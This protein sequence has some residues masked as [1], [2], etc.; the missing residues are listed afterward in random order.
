M[1]DPF[2][3]AGGDIMSTAKQQTKPLGL[4]RG[5]PTPRLYDAVIE[6]MRVRHHSRRT[7]Q[8]MKI[9]SPIFRAWS[10]SYKN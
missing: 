1:G 10:Q 4:F 7:E 9:L 3:R 2:T 6:A 8:A 5:K